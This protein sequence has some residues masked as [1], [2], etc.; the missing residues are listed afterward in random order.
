MQKNFSRHDANGDGFI[1]ADEA[2]A[3]PRPGQGGLPGPPPN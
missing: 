3:L 1:D 2:Q